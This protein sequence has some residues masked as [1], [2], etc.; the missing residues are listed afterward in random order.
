[1]FQTNLYTA[2]QRIEQAMDSNILV[3]N[4]HVTNLAEVQ[5]SL[6][7]AP[8]DGRFYWEGSLQILAEAS[9]FP[10][11]QPKNKCEKTVSKIVRAK[12]KLHTFRQRFCHIS[13]GIWL[14]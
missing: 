14:I 4:S 13:Q 10:V 8:P 3:W 11:S 6:W 5:R 7:V 1:M 9:S 2:T 12:S